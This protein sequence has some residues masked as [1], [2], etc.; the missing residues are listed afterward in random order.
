MKGKV[1]SN[2]RRQQFFEL[3]T[4]DLKIDEVFGKLDL[5]N[6]QVYFK[7]KFKAFILF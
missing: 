2:T 1:G 3:V 5:R 7:T 6:K 4:K